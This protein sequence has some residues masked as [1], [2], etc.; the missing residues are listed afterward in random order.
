MN[1]PTASNKLDTIREQLVSYEDKIIN[2]YI[3]CMENRSSQL[4]DV[5]DMVEILNIKTREYYHFVM[6]DLVYYFYDNNSQSFSNK[7]HDNELF[8]LIKERILLGEEVIKAKFESNPEIFIRV[9]KDG[10]ADK[11]YNILE[12]KEV[13]EKILNRILGKNISPKITTKIH[14]LYKEFIIPYTK[15]VQIVYCFNESLF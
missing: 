3:E 9:I 15:K 4:L 13:E 1:H 6:S 11:I 14:S 12:N 10:N 7:H 2:K 5:D 8:H